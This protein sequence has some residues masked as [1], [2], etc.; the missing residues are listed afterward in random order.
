MGPHRL[1]VK[2]FSLTSNLKLSSFSLKPFPLT[3]LLS[4]NHSAVCQH[5]LGLQDHHTGPFWLRI[6]RFCVPGAAWVLPWFAQGVGE[7]SLSSV[8]APMRD[9]C[10]SQPPHPHIKGARWAETK[11]FALGRQRAALSN[12]GTL[13]LASA[14]CSAL[15]QCCCSPA[16]PQP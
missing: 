1:R 8:A 6:L 15:P 4:N 14:E 7:R 12:P 2:G 13:Q 16:H 10:C 3:L 11:G 9:E 5:P